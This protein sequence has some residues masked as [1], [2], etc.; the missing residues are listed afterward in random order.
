MNTRPVIENAT[1]EGIHFSGNH[2]TI[3]NEKNYFVP[4]VL[5]GEIVTLQTQNRRLGF[6]TAKAIQIIQPSPLRTKVDCPYYENCGG[7]NFLHILYTEQL[8]LKQTIIHN[9]FA[10]YSVTSPPVEVSAVKNNLYYRNKATY[11]IQIKE[12]KVISGFHPLWD[13]K[14][15]LNINHCLIIKKEINQLNLTV[16]KWLQEN[17]PLAK[18]LFS[19]SI[20]YSETGNAIV[21]FE[22][23]DNITVDNE[24][25]NPIRQFFSGIYIKQPD[26]FRKIDEKIVFHERLNNVYLKIHPL[27]FFQNNYECTIKI[28][29]F[30]KDNLPINNNDV[31]YDLYSGNGSLSLTLPVNK[32]NSI[33][34]IDNNPYSI[35]DAR[36][37]ASLLPLNQNFQY[38]IGDILESFNDNL[39]SQYLSPTIIILD[40]PR[41]GT[42]IEIQKQIIRS[43][44]QYIV[45]VSCNPVSLAWNLQQLLSYYQIKAIQ[46]FDMFPQTHQVETVVILERISN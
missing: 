3:H 2:F 29:D 15:I 8:R 19:Y 45:Y 4:K 39:F 14:N 24:I 10:K 46:A 21:I 22:S 27:S 25:F 5:S 9:A 1:I 16:K 26:S 7:C 28:I 44:C 38:I 12:N 6:R 30:I 36:Y 17:L 33:I 43:G 35:N 42:L 18:L 32:T 11:R 37:N 31:I 20:R 40:P 13:S 41:S 34:G 23:K